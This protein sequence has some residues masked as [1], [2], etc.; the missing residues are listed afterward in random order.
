MSIQ[1]LKSALAVCLLVTGC[2]LP[3]MAQETKELNVNGLKIIYKKTGKEVITASVFIRGGTANYPADKQ[4]IEPLALHTALSG[5]FQ[6]MDKDT[7]AAE[8]DKMGT[9]FSES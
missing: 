8:L 4:G 3:A 2:L 1:I 9:E 6:G 5:G 7:L